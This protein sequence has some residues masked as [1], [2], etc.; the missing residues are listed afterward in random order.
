MTLIEPENHHSNRFAIPDKSITESSGHASPRL[1][2]TVKLPNLVTGFHSG[3]KFGEQT[4]LTETAQHN[5]RVRRPPT[6]AVP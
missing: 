6:R 4:P 1:P 2:W 5:L 3:D